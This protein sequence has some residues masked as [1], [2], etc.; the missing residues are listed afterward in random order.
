MKSDITAITDYLRTNSSIIRIANSAD[1]L[2]TV[3]TAKF[4]R[5]AFK[6]N[7]TEMDDWITILDIMKR[8][9]RE[10]CK[11]FFIKIDHKFEFAAASSTANLIRLQFRSDILYYAFDRITNTSSLSSAQS[12]Q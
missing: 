8:W 5:T 2:E 6:I 3:L 1:R 4:Q 12:F 9:K 10:N 7:I 11:Q